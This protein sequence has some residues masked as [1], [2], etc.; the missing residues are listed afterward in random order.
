MK[1]WKR[2]L[3][4][5]LAVSDD[6]SPGLLFFRLFLGAGMIVHGYPKLARGPALWE[7]LGGVMTGIGVP[8]PAVFWGFMAAF[9]EGVGG[10]L[11]IL[12]A[13]TTPAALLIAFTMGVAAFVA[14]AGDPFSGREK[15][16]LYLFGALV[17][18][19]KGA[20]RHS[21]DAAIRRRLTGRR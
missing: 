21:V 15:A 17:F 6:P 9:A 11:L 7:G 14:H 10:L 1:G 18:V 8:G 5:G 3:S 19:F 20:G 12:G 4:A 13:L 2:I 16:L